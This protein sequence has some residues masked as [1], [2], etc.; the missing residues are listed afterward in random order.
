MTWVLAR[1]RETEAVQVVKLNLLCP[2]IQAHLLLLAMMMVNRMGV[3][4]L[5]ALWGRLS[6]ASGFVN[7]RVKIRIDATGSVVGISTDIHA[8]R[9]SVDSDPTYRF[10]VPRTGVVAGTLA[11]VWAKGA[12]GER[13]RAVEVQSDHSLFREFAIGLPDGEPGTQAVFKV[14]YSLVHALQ[15]F[16]EQIRQK[17]TQKVVFEGSCTMPSVYNTTESV[18]WARAALFAGPAALFPNRD[19]TTPLA[20]SAGVAGGNDQDRHGQAAGVHSAR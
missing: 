13:L 2:Y 3:L 19:S 7:S 14:G 15:P 9:E 18:S 5:L 8:L 6:G 16:P 11:A 1:M 20:M 17:D 12:K 10:F 4:G